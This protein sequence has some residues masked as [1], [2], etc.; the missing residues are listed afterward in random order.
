MGPLELAA[1]GVGKA[2]TEI[3]TKYRNSDAAYM[4]LGLALERATGKSASTLYSEYLAAPLELEGTVLPSPAAALPEGNA[5]SG[6]YLPRE[7]GEFVCTE[8]VDIS[9]MSSSIGYTDSGAV[10]TIDD[11]G[12]YMRAMA[13]QTLAGGENSTR[14]AEPLPLSDSAA[15]WRQTT[16]G[17]HLV[18]PL[19]GQYGTVPGYATA[20]FSDPETGF[21]VAVVMNNSSGGG[22]PIGYL[23]WELAAIAS[24]VPA[25][26]GET[27]PEF[28][29]PFTADTYHKRI[30]DR[31]ICSPPAE[32]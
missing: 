2:R 28:A 9:R 3:K 22:M 18:G 14:W 15:R 24:K 27:E 17:A 19:I 25:A 16:G 8:P 10:S 12:R 21:T 32:D 23:A 30:A 29:L 4:L 7:D 5:L 13:T 11:L 20:A 26:S 31:A 1:Y 6:H